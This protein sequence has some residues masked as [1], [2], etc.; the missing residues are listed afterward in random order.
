MLWQKHIN[1]LNSKFHHS[2]RILDVTLGVHV[3]VKKI[4]VVATQCSC[5]IKY[6]RSGGRLLQENRWSLSQ[7][8]ARAKSSLTI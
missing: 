5:I 8:Q 1:P 4:S 3:G 6:L 7:V 2:P